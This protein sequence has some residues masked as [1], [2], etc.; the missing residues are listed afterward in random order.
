MCHVK[1]TFLSYEI[2]SVFLLLLLLCVEKSQTGKEGIRCYHVQHPH[3][4]WREKRCVFD[5]DLLIKFST[6]LIC[7]LPVYISYLSLFPAHCLLSTTP[8]T[9]HTHRR[10]EP[11]AR[12]VQSSVRGSSLVLMVGETGFLQAWIRSRIIFISV[13]LLEVKCRL[14]SCK[15]IQA[16]WLS[17]CFSLS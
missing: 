9:P 8:P 16:M 6:H 15:V 7:I 1:Q 2:H 14:S 17:I 4:R 10:A 11:S 13:S 5:D 3:P 12:L